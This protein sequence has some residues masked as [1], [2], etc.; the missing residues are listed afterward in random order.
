M[1]LFGRKDAEEGSHEIDE[2]LARSTVEEFGEVVDRLRVLGIEA[3]ELEERLLESVDALEGI[4]NP[5]LR[6]S[7]DVAFMLAVEGVEKGK[8]ILLYYDSA[9]AAIGHAERLID[10]VHRDQV[11]IEGNVFQH[12]ILSPSLGLLNGAKQSLKKGELEQV[13]EIVER[14][15]ILPKNVKEECLEN[16]ELYR[17]CEEL[18]EGLK[19]DGV[20]TQEIEDVMT[21]A[22]T[23]FLSGAFG[24][25]GELT[26]V[27]ERKA[28]E[29]KDRHRAA[30]RSLREARNA[31]NVLE[32][33]GVR[34]KELHELLG[35]AS[36]SLEETDYRECI[37]LSNRC[38]SNAVDIRRSHS[39]LAERISML[40]EEAKLMRSRGESVTDDIDE[41]LTRAEQEL[42]QGDLQDSE[43]DVEIASLMMG[44]FELVS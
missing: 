12:L 22:R 13:H 41:I 11:E 3:F 21:I 38:T 34:T 37:D 4:S 35:K 44:R 6:P 36:D 26:E 24:R 5:D 29:L 43:E 32:I 39:T 10:E 18:L 7:L 17:Y 40:R 23:A 9:A 15:E 25:V 30:G 2:R 19:R 16:A 20:G 28:V 27:I 8:N 14:I 31:V 1:K 42:V 33:K